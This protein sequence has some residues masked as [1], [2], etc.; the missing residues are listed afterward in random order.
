MSDLKDTYNKIA[1]EWSEDNQAV[2]WG[3]EGMEKFASL[4][5]KGG[6]IFDVGCGSGRIAKYFVQKGFH[7]Y[8]I[9]FSEKLLEIAKREVPNVEFHMMD[10]RDISSIE[11][12]FDGAIAVASFLHIKKTEVGSVFQSVVGKI[13]PGGFFFVS[14]KEVPP[15]GIKEEVKREKNYGMTFERFF[16]Y[17]TVPEVKKMFM[18]S[19]LD[20]IYESVEQPR[21]TRWITMIGRKP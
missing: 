13:K 20:I 10:M 1:E 7:I 8:G 14:V 19:G 2:T 17:Y 12:M 5:P 18:D 4:L 6:E 16:S 3:M 11:K 21:V 9:D 15:S